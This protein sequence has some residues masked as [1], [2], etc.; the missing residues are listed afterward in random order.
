[1]RQEVDSRDKVMHSEMSDWFFLEK[2][3]Y[4]GGRE[5]VTTDEERVARE[6]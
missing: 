1:M 2:K 4:I 3:M 5:R 6:G